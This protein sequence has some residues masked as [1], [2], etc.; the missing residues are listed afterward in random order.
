[1]ELNIGKMVKR[2]INQLKY[3]FIEDSTPVEPVTFPNNVSP[4]PNIVSQ[5]EP[6]LRRS[7]R[8][9]HLPDRYTG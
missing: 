6:E 5:P 4:S 3:R 2:H 7:S 1:M 9:R 8:D